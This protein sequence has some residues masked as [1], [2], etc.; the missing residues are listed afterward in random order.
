MD[1]DGDGWCGG[2]DCCHMMFVVG[3]DGT[4]LGHALGLLAVG[5]EGGE[6]AEEAAAQGGVLVGGVG[7]LEGPV[8]HLCVF[9]C[10]VGGW[11]G[12]GGGDDRL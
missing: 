8:G 10:G 6:D 11:G 2:A 4:H 9:V 7:E 5:L 3:G 12:E 1:G